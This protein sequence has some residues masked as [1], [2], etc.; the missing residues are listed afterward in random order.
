LPFNSVD[1]VLF[2]L[3]AALGVSR[4]LLRAAAARKPPPRRSTA[5][6]ALVV[7]AAAAVVAPSRLAD[8]S[9][10]LHFHG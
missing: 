2:S 3:P 9:E 8:A 6:H 1:F 7:F 5:R 4:A 10:F